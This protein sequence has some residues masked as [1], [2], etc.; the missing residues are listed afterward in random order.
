M[1][2]YV[3]KANLESN[4]YVN[5]GLVDMYSKFDSLVDARIIFDVMEDHDAI[6]YNAVIEGYANHDSVLSKKK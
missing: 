3:I 5:N 1:H 4:N 2:G 6:G